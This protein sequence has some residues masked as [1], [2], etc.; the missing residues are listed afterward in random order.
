MEF[1]LSPKLKM[2]FIQHQSER[3]KKL[4]LN[5]LNRHRETIFPLSFEAFF[6][7]RRMKDDA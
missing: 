7:P 6:Y 3:E 4:S 2:L 5:R 1:W